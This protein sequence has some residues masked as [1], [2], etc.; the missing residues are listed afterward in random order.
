MNPQRFLVKMRVE[1][2]MEIASSQAIT[3]ALTHGEATNPD[4][5]RR[6]TQRG[7]LTLVRVSSLHVGQIRESSMIC[8]CT[9]VARYF[10]AVHHT[11]KQTTRHD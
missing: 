9:F 7:S 5:L 3:I 11:S 1:K 4:D 10:Y 6:I 8:A 2:A